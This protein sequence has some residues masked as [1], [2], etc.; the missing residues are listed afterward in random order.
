MNQY[1]KDLP[2]K[3][4]RKNAPGAGRPIAVRDG[5]QRTMYVAD[6]DWDALRLIGNGSASEGL[7]VTLDKY[8]DQSATDKS[9]E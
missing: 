4:V 9:E 7:R 8:R 1:L 5:K 3:R 2:K 6:T